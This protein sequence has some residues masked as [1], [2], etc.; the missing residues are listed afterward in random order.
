MQQ[1][2]FWV[3]T[4][5]TWKLRLKQI[6]AHSCLQ[7][8]SMFT[9]ALFTIAKSW[10]QLKCP[11]V[12]EWISKTQHVC[13]Y[14]GLLLFSFKEERNPGTCYNMNESQ[15]HYAKWKSQSQKDKYYVIPLNTSPAPLKLIQF[16]PPLQ[17]LGSWHA[18]TW[19][20]LPKVTL[21]ITRWQ[22]VDSDPN[23]TPEL[24]LLGT[25]LWCS[26]TAL[27]KDWKQSWGPKPSATTQLLES[28][29]KNWSLSWARRQTSGQ[30]TKHLKFTR[31]AE[32][33]VKGTL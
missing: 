22:N 30:M 7:K 11:S 19:N 26:K 2:H 14:N 29:Q 33:E 9:E 12:G 27:S 16:L 18:E 32:V 4:Q 31:N 6:F 5:K 15:G 13:T 17:R 25:R 1:F 10:K 8:H 3:Y 28:Q 20:D 23:L 24:N 21:I